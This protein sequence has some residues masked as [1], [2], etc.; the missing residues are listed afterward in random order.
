[1]SS[2]ADYFRRKIETIRGSQENLENSFAEMQAELK[3][4]KSKMNN[5]E[6]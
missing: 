5:V 1:M 6:E 4:L 2:N 3:E